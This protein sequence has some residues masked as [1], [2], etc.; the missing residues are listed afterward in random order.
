LEASLFKFETIGIAA[1]N[2]P[3]DS[4]ILEILGVEKS[5]MADGEITDNGKMYKAAGTESDGTSFNVEVPTSV[6]IKAAWLPLGCGNRVTSPDVMRGERVIVYRFANTDSYFW[7]E[8][9][10]DGI[11]LRQLETVV[12]AIKATRKE[13]KA[14]GTNTYFMEMSSHNKLVHLHTSKDDGEPFAYDIQ[15]DTKNGSVQITDNEGCYISMDSKEQRLEMR[16]AEDSYVD[17]NKQDLFMGAK[18]NVV[19][20]TKNYKLKAVNVDVEATKATL[21]ATTNDITAAT[22]HKGNI[23]LLG[24]MKQTP[25][26]GGG[27]GGG[28]SVEFEANMKV[29]GNTEFTGDSKVNGT[30]HATKVISDQNIDAPNV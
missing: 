30:L 24:G 11:D 13:G 18:E 27:G 3:L 26:S 17:I 28:S 14:T 23:A 25:G 6:T 5:N 19:I 21:T 8:M 2:K 12:F 16:N 7:Q 4:N 29:Q 20:E 10:K 9:P 1:I 22:K 15:V